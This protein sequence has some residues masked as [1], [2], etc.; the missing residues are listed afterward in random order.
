MCST[1]GQSEVPSE[2]HQPSAVLFQV[3]NSKVGNIR[4]PANFVRFS[5]RNDDESLTLTV[6]ILIVLIASDADSSELLT[7]CRKHFLTEQLVA[8]RPCGVVVNSCE[9]FMYMYGRD[10]DQL[11]QFEEKGSVCGRFSFEEC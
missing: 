6:S 5:S 1:E 10:I 3:T 9:M 11:K 8:V 2:S 7:G 4:K